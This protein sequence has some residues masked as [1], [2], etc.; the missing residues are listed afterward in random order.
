MI[1][2]PC[3]IHS[4]VTKNTI[5]KIKL[6]NNN[7]FNAKFRIL[8]NVDGHGIDVT[9]PNFIANRNTVSSQFLFHFIFFGPIYA[10]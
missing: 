4:N 6:L 1:Q 7:N 3:D 5:Y 2:L 10:E 9:R 8:Y